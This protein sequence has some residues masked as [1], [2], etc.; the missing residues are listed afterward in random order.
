MKP[1][2]FIR[3]I[4]YHGVELTVYFNATPTIQGR[5]SSIPEDCYPDEGGEIEIT[6]IFIVDWDVTELLSDTV[7]RELVDRCAEYAQ[8]QFSAL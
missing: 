2:K 3:S 1:S 6:A 4:E 7:V 5:I 8:E